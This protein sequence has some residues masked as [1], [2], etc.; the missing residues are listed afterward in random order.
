MAIRL[1]D[2]Y[3]SPKE[4]AD[5][6]NVSLSTINRCIADCRTTDFKDAIFKVGGQN[7]IVE[8]RFRQFL[9]YWAK[10]KEAEKYGLN[11]LRNSKQFI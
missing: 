6:M 10:K 3:Y 1:A 8:M 4:M 7:R 11:D 2:E 9:D 5:K